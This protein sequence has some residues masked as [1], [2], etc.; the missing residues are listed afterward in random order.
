MTIHPVF[1]VTV[2]LPPDHLEQI[3]EAVERETS[4]GFG[5]YENVAWW[6]APGVE[7]FRPLATATPALGE[8][9]RVER[10]PSIRLE[11]ALPRDRALVE[12]VITRA[13]VPN[14]P[15]EEPVILV[16][17]SQASASHDA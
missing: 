9:G 7:Q 2:Y 5:H 13:I 8:V 15:W 6:S 16:D 12:R 3:L 1:R 14:H 17:E 4:L 10:A 11:F